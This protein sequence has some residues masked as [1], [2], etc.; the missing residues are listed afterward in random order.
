VTVLSDAA[1]IIGSHIWFATALTAVIGL[2]VGSFL[3]VVA[4]RLPRQLEPGD[5]DGAPCS[6]W[7][8]PSACPRCDHQIRPWHNIPVVSWLWLRG[9]C[10][11]CGYP[12]SAQY[13]ALEA[14]TGLL[15]VAIYVV[16]GWTPMLAPVLVASWFLL[17]IALID[18][19]T[20]LIP[21]ALSL[22][23]LWVG[24]VAS[25]GHADGWSTLTPAAAIGGAIGGYLALRIVGDLYRLATGV[26]GLGG[27]DPKLFGAI[28]AW[29]GLAWLPVV[30]VVASAA[31][32]IYVLAL[33]VRGHALRDVRFAFGPWLAAGGFACLLWVATY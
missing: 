20:Y 10:A 17:V 23:L 28:G 4:L 30:I 25:L 2:S 15:S 33:G 7:W 19:R 32:L 16:V 9:R 8:P 6:L 12:I 11:D 13:P 27:G 21:D 24:L 14:G 1:A 26:D 22:L 5:D 31:C 18:A 3:N 29:V